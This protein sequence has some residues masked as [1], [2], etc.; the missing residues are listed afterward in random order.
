[1][2]VS[3][4]SDVLELMFQEMLGGKASYGFGIGPHG[5]EPW[6]LMFAQAIHNRFAASGK[7]GSG[8]PIGNAADPAVVALGNLL[9]DGIWV[10]ECQCPFG[11]PLGCF[12]D[13]TDEVAPIGA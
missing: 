13:T 11:V 10:N 3:A 7:C 12:R 9:G 1:M 5:G 8:A 6:I 2:A 4:E